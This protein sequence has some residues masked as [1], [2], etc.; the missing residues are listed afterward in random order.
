MI[1][2]LSIPIALI[3]A[4]IS[5]MCG[6]GKPKLPWGL[7][8]WLYAIPHGVLGFLVAPYFFWVAY[9]GAFFGKR[10][11]HGQWFDLGTSDP[12]NEQTGNEPEKLDFILK[13]LY[14]PDDGSFRRDLMGMTLS[15]IAISLGS[16]LLLAFT[17]HLLMAALVLLGGA[18][19][20]LC[21]VVG[22]DL[23]NS[24]V[25]FS[26]VRRYNEWGEVLTGF[27]DWL[28]VSLC[29]LLLLHS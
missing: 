5:R 15:G 20:G 16:A 12:H 28:A 29:I 18:V 3:G 14:G 1:Q 10:T 13:W 4:K 8:Q 27:F 26:D 22:T 24:G 6:G 11:G 21:Y 9:F 2:L 17:G 19:K 23:E 25:G 7:D